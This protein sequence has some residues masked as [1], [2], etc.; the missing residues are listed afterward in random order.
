MHFYRIAQEAVA[1]ALRQAHA[2]H[3]FIR[4]LEEKG[5]FKLQIVDDGAGFPAG[6]TPR[7]PGMG[8][9]IMRSRA[10]ASGGELSIETSKAGGTC[11]TC[12]IPTSL[13]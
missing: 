4:L 12:L 13:P 8:L 11:L 2:R 10:R 5:C 1:N 6:S 9:D 7:G 3:I